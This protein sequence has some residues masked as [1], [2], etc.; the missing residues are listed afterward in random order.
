[1]FTVYKDKSQL[2]V[3]EDEHVYKVEDFESSCDD[4]FVFLTVKLLFAV[5]GM[6]RSVLAQ[7]RSHLTPAA[8]KT[9]IP[10]SVAD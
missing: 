9:N 7:N 4:S 2:S 8:K 3:I 10:D 5:C 1:M 6:L